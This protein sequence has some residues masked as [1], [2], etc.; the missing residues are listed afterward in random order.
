MDTATNELIA[1]NT[2]PARMMPAG[3]PCGSTAASTAQPARAAAAPMAALPTGRR[4]QAVTGRTAV[5]RRQDRPGCL[6]VVEDR[7]H[8]VVDQRRPGV[9]RDAG[10]L[11]G[12]RGFALRVPHGL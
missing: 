4:A 1:P 6:D 3:A 7:Q 10:G 9:Q 5:G 8:L 12:G 2:Q 11:Q